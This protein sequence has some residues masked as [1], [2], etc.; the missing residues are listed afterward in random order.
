MRVVAFVLVALLV[1]VPG[2]LTDR[3]DAALVLAGTSALP[4]GTLNVGIYPSR[5]SGSNSAQALFDVTVRNDDTASLTITS[6]SATPSVGTVTISCYSSCSTGPLSGGT[7]RTITFRAF[8]ANN[9]ASGTVAGSVTI[10]SA[11]NGTV[12]VPVSVPVRAWRAPVLGPPS[13][14]SL[15]ALMPCPR[16][17]S[18][19]FFD[20]A[21][22]LSNSGDYFYTATVSFSGLPFTVQ[23]MG[24][25][26]SFDVPAN[27]AVTRSYRVQVSQFTSERDYAGTITV[28]TD[29]NAVHTRVPLTVSV[30]YPVAVTLPASGNAVD[31]GDV[32]LLSNAATWS[33]PASE[34]CGYKSATIT[35]DATP[36]LPSFVSLN[37]PSWTIPAGG[38]TTVGIG[39]RFTSVH[40]ALLYHR[41]TFAVTLRAASPAAAAT[42]YSFSARPV[43][44]DVDRYQKRL[45]SA[46]D[47]STF[48]DAKAASHQILDA[49]V[50]RTQTRPP[51]SDQDIADASR[52]VALVEPT[53]I[54]VEGFESM[55]R[56]DQEGLQNE[57]VRTLLSGSV[58]LTTLDDA[59]RAVTEAALRDKCRSALQSLRARLTLFAQDVRDHFAALATSGRSDLE[60]ERSA[61]GLGLALAALGNETSSKAVLA[62]AQLHFASFTQRLA[63]ADNDTRRIE[64]RTADYE[65]FVFVRQGGRFVVWNPIGFP[66]FSRYV[67]GTRSDYA[68]A[69]G[70]LVAAGDAIR[71]ASLDADRAAFERSV[72]ASA[73]YNLAILAAYGGLFSGLA[74]WSV[75]GWRRRRA[76]ARFAALG[77]LLLPHAGPRS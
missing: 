75:L 44:I 55:R 10:Q 54:L 43:F 47:A 37:Q 30:L 62:Q 34:Q 14:V 2:V 22:S 57:T 25:L 39:V 9:A 36:A 6:I 27:G 48:D 40:N 33:G 13:S 29:I 51:R 72:D 59:C 45:E 21:I 46:R 1:A 71:L 56:W 74:A 41:Q 26:G 32:P 52:V 76:H 58:A 35:A 16:S 69:R 12:S 67:A 11:T 50:D 23:S 28:D 15:P 38:S 4:F 77:D 8:A 61:T 18:D 3:V 53:A 7:S 60:L 31:F 24:G 73:V 42:T 66:V 63:E 19:S 65:P 70:Q 20:F 49:L 68:D 64:R 5:Y 17:S